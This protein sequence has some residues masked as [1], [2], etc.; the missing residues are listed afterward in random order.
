MGFTRPNY[1]NLNTSKFEIDDPI[2]E[3]NTGIAD[4]DPSN[5]DVGFIFNRGTNG[6]NVALLWSKLTGTFVIGTTLATGDDV[7]EVTI[8]SYSDLRVK[9]LTADNVVSAGLVLPIADGTV[10]QVITTDGSGTL[11]FQDASTWGNIN[12]NI[13]D[14]LDLIDRF[15]NGTTN[16]GVY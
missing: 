15:N 9:T 6:D 5:S 7:G 10:G 3:L 2:T 14:Q 1:N 4:T 13:D 11:T 12:G 8:T 16:G